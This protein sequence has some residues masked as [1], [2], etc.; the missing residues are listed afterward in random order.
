MPSPAESPREEPRRL[1]L[2]GG[3]LAW[4]RSV[5][6]GGE[7]GTVVL[8]HGLASNASRF[9]EFAEQTTLAPAWRVLRVDLRGHGA[10]QGFAPA[11]LEC[12]CDDLAAVLDAESSARAVF[13]GHSLGAQVALRMAQRHPRRVQALAL[14]DPVFLDALVPR[15]RRIVRLLPLAAAASRLVH[16]LN[17]LGLRRREVR[18][19]DLRALDAEARAALADPA[20]EAEFVRRYS[21]MRGDLKQIRTA[22]YLRDLVE[23]FRPTPALE[24]IA[25][26][27]LALL[28]TGATFADHA[29]M[30]VGL[31]QLP[32]VEVQTIECHHWP[33]TERPV[34]V[35]MA[36]ERWVT[37]LAAGGAR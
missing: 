33:L 1:K 20:R 29:A 25:V 21:S 9:A 17:R 34:D 16:A 35:R 3:M 8:I 28:S 12:W 22:Q 31:G 15:W 18:P 30:L 37:T 26:P 27:V 4:W 14:I 7:R 10:S 32:D 2:D 23:M 6:S 5:P 13:V 24:T 36:I 11:T 19:G